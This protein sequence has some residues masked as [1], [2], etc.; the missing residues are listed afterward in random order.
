MDEY[1]RAKTDALFGIMMA[2]N[3]LDDSVFMFQYGR[4][5]ARAATDDDPRP[6]GG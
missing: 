5:E 1:E 3:M 6:A 2:E 4:L